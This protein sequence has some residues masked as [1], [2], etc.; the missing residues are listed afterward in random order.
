MSITF[1][2]RG[3]VP[4]ATVNTLLNAMLAVAEAEREKLN[5]ALRGKSMFDGPVYASVYYYLRREAEFN[6]GHDD[7]HPAFVGAEGLDGEPLQPRVR[8]IPYTGWSISDDYYGA[9]CDDTHW[10]TVM[11]QV[12]EQFTREVLAVLGGGS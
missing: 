7:S 5:E 8:L 9:G 6:M 12:R 1:N 4:A 11:K 3:K 10:A 2:T